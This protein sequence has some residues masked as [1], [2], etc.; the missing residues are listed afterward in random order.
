[1]RL[2]TERLFKTFF[3]WSFFREAIII[4]HRKKVLNN[5]SVNKR[6]NKTRKQY[7]DNLVI[8]TYNRSTYIL[9][10]FVG[11]TFSIYNGKEFKNLF[12]QKN[13]VGC[14]LGEFSLTRKNVSLKGSGSRKKK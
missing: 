5:L 9:P 12:I 3:L 11:Q 10:S 7:V 4:D 6:K 8:K 13:M 14:R 2:F 1:L